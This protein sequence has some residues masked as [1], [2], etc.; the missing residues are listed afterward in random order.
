MAVESDSSEETTDVFLFDSVFGICGATDGVD[1][2]LSDLAVES[3]FS[4]ETTGVLLFDSVFGICGA[5]DGVDCFES[6]LA[7]ESDFSEETTGVLLFDSIFGICGASV[8]EVTIWLVELL[9]SPQ[10]TNNIL[11]TMV[12]SVN[13]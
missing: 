13:L 8:F 11:A 7:V 5:T 10:P 6:D 2:F 3:D 4:E 9:N 12:V 1:C